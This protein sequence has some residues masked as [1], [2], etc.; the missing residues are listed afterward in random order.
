MKSKLWE[1]TAF[2]ITIFIL[3][4]AF[5]AGSLCLVM[6]GDARLTFLRSNNLD[7]FSFS[8]SDALSSNDFLESDSFRQ[9]ASNKIANLNYLFTSFAGKD[10]LQVENGELFEIAAT[11]RIGNI[12]NAIREDVYNRYYYGVPDENPSSWNE[13]EN[14]EFGYDYNSGIFNGYDLNDWIGHG[15]E[16]LI[17]ELKMLESPLLNT[18]NNSLRSFYADGVQ[19]AFEALFPEQMKAVREMVAAERRQN[20]NMAMRNLEGTLYFVNDGER[21]L[22]NVEL[23][24]RGYLAD[25]DVFRSQG[26]WMAVDQGAALSSPENLISNT[27]YI[28][29]ELNSGSLYIAWTNETLNQFETVYNE[30]RAIIWTYFAI[31][32]AMFICSVVFLIILIV[33]TG[34]KRPSYENTRKLWLF[35]KIFVEFQI[36]LFL[37]IAIAGGYSFVNLIRSYDNAWIWT[38]NNGLYTAL[39]LILGFAVCSAALWFL[40]SLIRVAKAG[41]VVKRSL[42][43]IFIN[44][45][46]RRLAGTIK[47][48]FDGRNPLAKSILLIIL[49]WFVTSLFAGICG[50]MI[51]SSGGV[52]FVFFVLLFVILGITL[53]FTRKWAERYGHLRKGVEEISSGNLKYQIEITGD[54]KNEFEKL[55]AMVNELGTAQ[56]TAIQN[57]L[58]NQRLKT[59]LISNVSHDLKT[60]LTS[61][62]TYTDLLKKEGL[63]SKD[64]EEYLQIIDEKGKRL[65]KLTEDL[66]DAAKAS[67]GAIAVRKEKVDLLALINQEIAE[68]NG[69]F[70]EAGLELVIDAANEHY[71]IEADGQLLWRVIDNLLRNVRKYAQGGT[72]VYIDLK[73]TSSPGIARAGAL[74]MTTLEI[75]NTSATKLNIPPEELMERF[76][77]GDESRATEGSG[78]GLA[79]SK[80]LVR[81]QGGWFEVFI[82]GDLFKVVVMFPP[83]TEESDTGE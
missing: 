60:P 34:R 3:C 49:L 41:L 83:Y 32:L 40:L 66:F 48:G 77:R 47:T 4:A 55:S 38:A 5:A 31:A 15:R 52:A 44:G 53:W 76:R 45:P 35:D 82:D 43:G 80:D 6:M 79:I 74:L 54:G 37:I 25:K 8:A 20:F 28:L 69:S 72:R 10:G 70:A 63:K 36:V 56:N 19:E 81:L 65:Q 30:A 22:S 12:Y 46:C 23:D 75:K 62:L 2:R 39:V 26:A 64:A 51:N 61:I 29:D 58:K 16:P 7:T 59:D 14:Y 17:D 68:F 9:N 24:S 18:G 27:N 50:V 67:S 13:Y 21:T 78:L 33:Q 71:Y 57:E 11:E 42:I 73:E 1:R